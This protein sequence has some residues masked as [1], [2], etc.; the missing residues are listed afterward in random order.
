LKKPQTDI[1]FIKTLS[2][3]ILMPAFHNA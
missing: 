2:L 1:F 3:T